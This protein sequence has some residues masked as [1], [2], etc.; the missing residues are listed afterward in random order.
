M[1]RTPPHII[2]CWLSIKWPSRPSF[3]MFD[4]PFHQHQVPTSLSLSMDR[5]SYSRPL[6]QPNHAWLLPSQENSCLQSPRHLLRTSKWSWVKWYTSV[7]SGCW[8]SKT[9]PSGLENTNTP[10]WNLGSQSIPASQWQPLI[11]CQ[12]HQDSYSHVE[13]LA[14]RGKVQK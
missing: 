8:I 9:L 14:P 3:I 12:P 13:M 11:V 1:S 2:K 7:C 4:S 10:G 6:Q 5:P